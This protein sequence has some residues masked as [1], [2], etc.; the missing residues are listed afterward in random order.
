MSL[1]QKN[2]NRYTSGCSRECI[3]RRKRKP[4][5]D[6]PAEIHAE[7]LLLVCEDLKD[8]LLVCEDLLLMCEDLLLV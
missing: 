1:V 8:L 3:A 4:S 6:H 5:D 2:Q 7:D